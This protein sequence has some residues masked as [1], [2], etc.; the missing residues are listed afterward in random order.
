MKTVLMIVLF[1]YA[2]V[3]TSQGPPTDEVL[4]NAAVVQLV[5][6]GLTESVVVLKIRSSRNRFDTSADALLNLKRQGVPDAVIAAMIEA[7]SGAGVA[8]ASAPRGGGFDVFLETAAGPRKMQEAPHR[9]AV[10]YSLFSA[11][12]KTRVPG[13]HAELEAPSSS[14]VFRVVLHGTVSIRQIVLSRFND[15]DEGGSR[16]LNPD[17]AEEFS[18]EPLPDGAYRIMPRTPLKK[19]EYCIYNLRGDDTSSQADRMLI[20][21]FTVPARTRD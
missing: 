8:T 18:A 6:G 20:F 13:R 11:G 7:P 3:A 10:S 14:P 4:T 1:A 15:S 9:S 12:M 19:G 17:S 2:S 21:D 5:K 16:E